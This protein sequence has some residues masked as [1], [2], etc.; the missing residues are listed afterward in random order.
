[1]KNIHKLLCKKKTF[2]LFSSAYIC[3]NAQ[4]YQGERVEVLVI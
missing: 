1:M 2:E 3:I 4:I